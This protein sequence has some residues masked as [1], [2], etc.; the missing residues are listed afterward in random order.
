MKKCTKSVESEFYEELIKKMSLLA[1]RFGLLFGFGFGF[2]ISRLTGWS[3]LPL[4]TA[5]ILFFILFS[6]KS[7]K[8]FKEENVE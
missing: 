1:Y 2:I 8:K 3:F 6:F 4:G 7:L 5:I